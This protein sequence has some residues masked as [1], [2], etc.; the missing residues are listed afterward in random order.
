VRLEGLAYPGGICV[1]ARVQE[2]AAGKLDFTF[3]DTGEQVLKNIARPVRVY[4]VRRER[5]VGRR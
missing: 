5:I 2:D 4:R 3:E 1:S